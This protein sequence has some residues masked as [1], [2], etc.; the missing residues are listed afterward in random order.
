MTLR[1]LFIIV[2]SGQAVVSVAQDIQGTVRNQQGDP[3]P[4]ALVK[5]AQAK[6]GTFTN[7]EGRYSLSLPVAQ[8]RLLTVSY[9]G[10]EKDS[11]QVSSDLHTVDFILKET[12]ELNEA[13]VTAI[14]SGTYKSFSSIENVDMITSTELCR[15]ACCN[16]GESFVTNPSVDVSYNDAATGA[17][18][19]RLLGLS[20]TYVQ[21]MT[22][23]IPNFR[24]TASPYGLGYIPGPWMQSIQVSKGVS[25]VKNGYE[26]LTGQIN[27]EYKKPQQPEPDWMAVNLFGDTDGKIEGNIDATFKLGQRWGTTVLGHYEKETTV[28]DANHDGFSDMPQV[29][30]Y[31]FLNRWTYSGD[32]YIF[33]AGVKF[34]DEKRKSGQLRMGHS[35]TSP[36]RPYI[37]DISTKRYEAFSKNAYIFDKEHNTNVALI[38]SGSWHNQESAYGLRTYD[39]KQNNAYASLLFETE[40]NHS[41]RLSTGISFNHDGLSRHYRPEQDVLPNVVH[42]KNNEEVAGAYAQYTFSLDDKFLIMAGLRADHSNM[43]GTFVT[44]RAHLKFTPNLFMSFRLSAGKGYRSAYVLDENN[45]LFAGSRKVVASAD[46]LREEAWNYGVSAAFKIPFNDKFANL[47][48]EYYYTDFARQVVIDM[49]SDP[50]AVYLREL[51]GRSYSQVIQVEASYPFFKGFTMTAAY[52]FTDARTNYS[53]RLL[54]RPLVSRYKTL[55][56]ASYKTPLEIWQFDATL[57]INGGGRM[58]TPYTL[59]NGLPSWAERYR[60]FPQLSAQ[61][62]RYFR[63]WSI[64]VGGENLTGF[65]QKNPIV[66]A[67]HPWG[68][69]FDPTMIWGPTHGVKV[70][71]GV[72]YNIPR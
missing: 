16:L 30:Q 55:L 62:T 27:V 17:K 39:V 14:R 60:S 7:E 47:N 29:E 61:I 63:H 20:G 50:H 36:E 53:G 43:F 58:P 67:V 54:R 21:M 9:V 22:E 24:I 32:K 65:K 15:A 13:T 35:A 69:N 70:Y 44:P 52:R 45:Y 33:Q 42:G 11:L 64:Y 56:T 2:L 31:N 49:D 41:H 18:Q 68:E 72:R 38:L 4:G 37:I 34:I 19:I 23:N 25:S 51:D 59:D 40:L 28:H 6:N 3:L 26:A 10:Y 57:Q 12:S 5:W 8:N 71:A 48:V 1:K 66:D 46:C